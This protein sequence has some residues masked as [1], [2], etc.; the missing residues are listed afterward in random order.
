MCV[1]IAYTC[2]V[3][4]II[5]VVIVFV[6]VVTYYYDDGMYV[7]CIFDI[8]AIDDVVGVY[9]VVDI[10]DCD[11]ACH[12][13]VGICYVVGHVVVEYLTYIYDSINMNVDCIVAMRAVDVRSLLQVCHLC[14]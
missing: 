5:V 11:V 1:D 4:H 8:A 14:N 3:N 9:I 10:G 6:V 13:D 2:I 12:M 7:V